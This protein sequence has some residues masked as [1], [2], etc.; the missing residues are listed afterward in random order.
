[1]PND[2]GSFH[3]MEQTGEKEASVKKKKE[4]KAEMM[5]KKV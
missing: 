1:M 4:R 3:N 5:E 2:K